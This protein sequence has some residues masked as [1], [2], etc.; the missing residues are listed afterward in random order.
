MTTPNQLKE[1]LSTAIIDP[2]HQQAFDSAFPLLYKAPALL[3]MLERL[4]DTPN[5]IT[6][7]IEAAEL[8][9]SMKK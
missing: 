6:L 7:L 9:D 2:E 3:N 8:V 4:I 1:A 5:N